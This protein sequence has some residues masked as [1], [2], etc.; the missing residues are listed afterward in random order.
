MTPFSFELP[1]ST[2]G[3]VHS[4]E[5]KPS[6]SLRYIQNGWF[7]IIVALESL[8]KETEGS[9][10]LPGTSGKTT[11]TEKFN[12]IVTVDV[13]IFICRLTGRPVKRN[14]EKHAR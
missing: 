10:W 5:N 1:S 8:D 12:I 13:C 4:C 6:Q 3:H 11:D 14:E 9:C 7:T 2:M